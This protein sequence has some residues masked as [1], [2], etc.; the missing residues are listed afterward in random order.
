MFLKFQALFLYFR[1]VF[2]INDV[3]VPPP[4]LP[5]PSL[6]LQ[7]FLVHARPRENM[8]NTVRTN[9]QSVVFTKQASK[10]NYRKTK[11]A[12]LVRWTCK[13]PLEGHARDRRAKHARW[14]YCPRPTKLHRSDE[15]IRNEGQ[16]ERK[17]DGRAEERE[18]RCLADRE[19]TF[20]L[21][22]QGI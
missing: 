6:S 19:L 18:I 14:N 20:W 13:K 16:K 10:P 8:K 4:P 11:R 9:G 21:N 7:T 15:S 17:V 1:I 2:Y 12:K 22:S 5:C 3:F